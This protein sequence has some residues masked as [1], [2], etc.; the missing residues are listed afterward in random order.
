MALLGVAEFRRVMRYPPAILSRLTWIE[1]EILSKHSVNIVN[2][3]VQAARE[4]IAQ[5]EIV[6]VKHPPA[7]VTVQSVE[8]AAA[9]TA[10]G[11][12]I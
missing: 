1:L 12:C 11:A 3:A 10:Q 9:V 2:D 6:P 7:L 4:L 5:P 8:N